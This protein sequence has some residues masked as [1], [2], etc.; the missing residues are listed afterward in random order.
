MKIA[1]GDKE[2][3]AVFN[4]FTPIAYSRNFKEV[5]NDGVKRPKDI[6]EAVGMIAASMATYG[7]PSITGLL[8]IFYACIKTASPK[9]NVSFEDW[10]A[11]F[12]PDAYDL[13]RGDGWAADV[14]GIVEENFFHTSASAV[15]AAPAETSDAAASDKSK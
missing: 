15:E 9:F 10:A 11:G 6:S 13:E 7:I 8:E 2:H 12:P 1:V 14:M 4:G 3:E 5:R